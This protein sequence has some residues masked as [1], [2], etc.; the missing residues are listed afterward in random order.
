MPVILDE[1]QIVELKALHRTLEDKKQA[2]KIKM[3][4]MWNRGFTATQIAEALIIDETTVRRNI[5]RYRRHGL[6]KYLKS[7]YQGSQSKLSEEQRKEIK[8]HFTLNTPQ[9]ASEVVA[10]IKKKY[11]ISYSTIGVTKLMHRLG[12]VYKKPKII[13][14]KADLSKQAEFVTEYEETKKNLEKDDQIYF[15]DATHPTHNTK[16]TY[17]WILR[18]KKNDKYIKSNTGRSRL[19]LHGATTLA[20][21]NT[22][23]LEEEKTINALSTIRLLEELNREQKVGKVYVILDNARY[24]HANLVTEWLQHHLRFKLMFLPPYSPNL[25]IIERLWKLYHTKITNNQYFENFKDFKKASLEFFENLKQ[26]KPELDSLLTDNFQ[27]LP[28]LNAISS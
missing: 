1:S 24:Y 9:T 25:N 5:N 27:T 11:G 10:Y 26:Y 17:G 15:A 22:V 23:V 21:K 20:G 18:G 3:V 8:A 12:F 13:P 7:L 4:V 2:D 28:D 19:N 14:G 16:A 6:E